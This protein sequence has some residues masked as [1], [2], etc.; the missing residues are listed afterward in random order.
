MVSAIVLAAGKS[1]RMGQNKLLLPL[2][3]KPLLNWVLDAVVASAVD[4]IV[5]VTGRDADQV[6]ALVA[7]YS[8]RCVYNAQYRLGQ[9]GSISCG[10]NALSRDSRYC[11]F[12]M[13]D[14]PFI[15]S[16]LIDA[17]IDDFQ[18]GDILQPVYRGVPGT[19]VAFDACFYEQLAA[20]NGDV[21]GKVVIEQNR[22]NLRQY[23]WYAAQSFIDIDNP[24][25]F[26]RAQLQ[27]LLGKNF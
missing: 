3:G 2:A 22:A 23:N 1:A 26:E 15:D 19:P 25:D 16:R 12:V 24:S 18:A 11:F 6:M 27:L 5:V 17:L 8:L 10:V 9:G 13:G 7:D 21:G 20:L 4:E 14:Q